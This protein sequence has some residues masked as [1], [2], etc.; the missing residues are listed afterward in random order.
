LGDAETGDFG[1]KAAPDLAKI[2]RPRGLASDRE[3]WSISRLDREPRRGLLVFV[4]SH[5]CNAA[6]SNRTVRP[7]RVTGIVGSCRD[8]AETVFG[9]TFSSVATS[10]AVR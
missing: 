2:I 3:G 9:E 10:A 1:V 8:Q 6:S 5:R 7:M 4:V